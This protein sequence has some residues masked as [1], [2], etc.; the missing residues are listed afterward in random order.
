[1]PHM[2]MSS[3]TL[4]PDLNPTALTPQEL[5]VG[6]RVTVAVMD[7]DYV[8]IL[9]E[10]LAH[11]P[12]GNLQVRTDPVSTWLGGSERDIAVYLAALIAQAGRSGA[13]VSASI[14][15]SRGCPGEVVCA[16][17]AGR[18]PQVSPL[19]LAP[20]GIHAQAQWALYPLADGS[21]PQRPADHMRDIYAAIDQARRNGVVVGSEHYVTVLAGDLADVI[22][23]VVTAWA[24]VGAS[25]QH[26]TSH[27]TISVNS[28]TPAP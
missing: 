3:R 1:M 10:A 27:L 21:D 7:S 15:L 20:T 24:T 11:A 6:A 16:V 14:L 2:A 25:V 12:A 8:S 19:D 26:V 5:G 23:T 28:P 13:H 4:T 9:T 22:A 18:L 17:P